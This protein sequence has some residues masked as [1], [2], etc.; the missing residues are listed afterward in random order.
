MS[1]IK[2][3]EWYKIINPFFSDT[4]GNLEIASKAGDVLSH[5]NSET[6]SDEEQTETSHNSY[7]EEDGKE[8]LTSTSESWTEGVKRTVLNNSLDIK[9]L[10]R[11]KEELRESEQMCWEKRMEAQKER[12]AEF[13]AFRKEKAELNRLHELETLEIFMKH[14]NPPPKGAQQ[15]LRQQTMPA[16]D[17]NPMPYTPQSNQVASGSQD[18]QVLDIDSQNDQRSMPWY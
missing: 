13:L 12:H 2:E 16:Q 4:H 18:S 7:Q 11:K 14:L 6:D 9:P 8:D 17:Y 1:L 10:G 3:P 5:E 15:H